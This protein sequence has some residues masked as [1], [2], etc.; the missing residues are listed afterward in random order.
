MAT[1]A[2]S[3]PATWPWTL[4]N[5]AWTLGSSA[6]T[7][8][9]ATLLQAI[10]ASL[11]PISRFRLSM[12]TWKLRSATQRRERSRTSSRSRARDSTPS[13]SICRSATEGG[14]R[15]K[16]AASTLSSTEGR[17]ASV[18]ARPGAT[19]M[20]CTTSLSS[21]GLAW[22]IEKS[23]TPAGRPLRNRSKVTNA[24]SGSGAS[25]MALSRN[26]ISSVRSSRARGLRIARQR[27]WC[28]PRTAA[29]TISGLAKP[30]RA[31]V[32]SVSGSGSPPVKTRLPPSS[33]AV[34]AGASSNSS[35]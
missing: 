32:A 34:S 24:P 23:C 1:T 31:R 2:R 27:P 26:G 21:S 3:Q 10:C 17:R 35:A 12:P 25:A 14:S 28:Q 9:S 15:K 22:N 6:L 18:V 7:A 4:A 29:S 19:P 5:S 13:S 11:V 8:A 20:T 33:E 30:R 16:S